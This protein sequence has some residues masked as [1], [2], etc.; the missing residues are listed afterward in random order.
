MDAARARQEADPNEERA[1]TLTAD[2]ARAILAGDLAGQRR[3]MRLCRAMAGKASRRFG[4]NHES[5]EDI[6]QDTLVSLLGES[7]PRLAGGE[8]IGIDFG[9]V[10]FN[11]ARAIAQRYVRAEIAARRHE[12]VD[13]FGDDRG[14]DARLR[15]APEGLRDDATPETAAIEAE[16]ERV[17]RAAI[18]EVR[19]QLRA[20][21]T[22]LPP[23]REAPRRERRAAPHDAAASPAGFMPPTLS[24]V[25]LAARITPR[26]AADLAGFAAPVGWRAASAI[27]SRDPRYR[28]VLRAS[29]NTATGL[30][31]PLREWCEAWGKL[32]GFEPG[33]YRG[34]ADVLGQHY[35]TLFRWYQGSA[36]PPPAK[37]A[38]ISGR[39]WCMLDD[40]LALRDDQDVSAW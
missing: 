16:A 32:M 31:R 12:D 30:A 13:G 11:A 2:E 39:V 6:A 3:L 37:V 38:E 9:L 24:D 21:P 8:E 23:A 18:A 27:H 22:V 29:G 20:R 36:A 10:V 28:A 26:A 34:L 25:Y 17:R 4:V 40:G 19:A 7:L 1:E 5:I 33:D 15:R 35:T 14:D